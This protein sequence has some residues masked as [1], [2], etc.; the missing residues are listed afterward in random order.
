MARIRRVR[1]ARSGMR[2][3]F[4]WARCFKSGIVPAQGELNVA[5]L[6]DFTNE[7]GAQ[8][9]GATIM[10]I[11]GVGY[12]SGAA[13]LTR[14]RVRAG[15]RVYT[16]DTQTPANVGNEPGPESAPHADWM[17]WYSTILHGDPQGTLQR[18]ATAFDRFVVDT[19]ANRRLEELGQ[20]LMLSIA[21]PAVG[22]AVDASWDLSIG[23]KL[24]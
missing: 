24:P 16:E 14:S 21:N 1:S 7:Y 12:V 2:R 4:V 11:R 19:K 22:V 6:T 5:L 23:L 9:L 3:K 17:F 18:D 20:G 15:I 13:T 10:R 8:L